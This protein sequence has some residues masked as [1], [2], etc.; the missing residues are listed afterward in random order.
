MADARSA[1]KTI[2]Q[3]M[4]DQVDQLSETLIER[5]AEIKRLR[6]ALEWISANDERGWFGDRARDALG[7]TT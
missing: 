4:V 6:E 3:R 2:E 1:A 7:E 5:N